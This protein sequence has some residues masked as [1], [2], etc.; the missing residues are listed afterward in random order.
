MTWTIV[1]PM[2]TTRANTTPV[3]A[4]PLWVH[5]CPAAALYLGSPERTVRL[6]QPEVVCPYCGKRGP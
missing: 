5:E 2:I 4:P 3:S 6:V 1:H